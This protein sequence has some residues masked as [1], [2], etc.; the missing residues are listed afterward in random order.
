VIELRKRNQSPEIELVALIVHPAELVGLLGGQKCSAIFFTLLFM[1]VKS[2]ILL[3]YYN[4]E[5]VLKDFFFF[6]I[7]VT[8]TG[9]KPNPFLR[10]I[11]DYCVSLLLKI[12]KD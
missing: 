9:S 11:K 3:I 8:A 2:T 1:M 10:T 5:L 4:L 12:P 7:L 6:S